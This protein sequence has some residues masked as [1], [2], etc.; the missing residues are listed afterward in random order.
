M[1]VL[2]DRASQ[3]SRSTDL[4]S[5]ISGPE[6]LSAP[7]L[8]CEQGEFALPS[9]GTKCVKSDESVC[10]CPA[11]LFLLLCYVML[12]SLLFPYHGIL[13][14][15]YASMVEYF[16]TGQTTCCPCCKA[17]G[18]EAIQAFEPRRSFLTQMDTESQQLVPLQ[19]EK[20]TPAYRKLLSKLWQGVSS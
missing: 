6:C 10:F 20:I 19:S 2:E 7:K 15:S 18:P 9:P 5:K 16:K 4:I 13:L 11:P 14:V 8:S 3:S 1:E 12:L 17:M